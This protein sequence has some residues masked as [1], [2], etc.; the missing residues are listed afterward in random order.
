MQILMMHPLAIA[1]TFIWIGLVLGIS[2]L[3]A[4]LKFKAPGVTTAIGLGIGRLVFRALNKV[5]W[6]LAIVLVFIAIIQEGLSVSIGNVMLLAIVA[7][8]LAQ[9]AWLLPTLDSRAQ[10]VINNQQVEPSRLHL[11]F[12]AAEMVKVGLLFIVGASLLDDL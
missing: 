12:I 5:E 9:T 8:L 11:I 4:W 3:E 2:F 7:I 10:K 1:A 6:L